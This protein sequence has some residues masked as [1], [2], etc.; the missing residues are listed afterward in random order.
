MTLRIKPM[1]ARIRLPASL[2]ALVMSALACTATPKKSEAPEDLLS[3]AVLER[4]ALA[5][6]EDMGVQG[7]VIRNNANQRA[8][9]VEDMR[10]TRVLAAQA[11]DA[12]L[13]ASPL[14]KQRLAAQREN[15]L[16]GLYLENQFA[17]LANDA[18]QRAF[19]EKNMELFS[20]PQ[21][22]AFHIVTRTEVAATAAIAALQEPGAKRDVLLREFAPSAPEGASSGDLGTFTR[23]QMLKPIEDAVFSTPVGKVHPEPVRTAHGWHAIEV[24]GEIPAK[25]V[26]FEDV[27]AEVESALKSEL[28]RK[29]VTGALSVKKADEAAR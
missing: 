5:R 23:G 10:R 3:D 21:R 16:A 14:F 15:I 11:V 9:F 24:T 18:A 6:L 19:F 26:K 25:P 20:K 28:H 22:S 17:T 4:D 2:L 13:D 27:R 7:A 12:G 8:A 1:K 29:I